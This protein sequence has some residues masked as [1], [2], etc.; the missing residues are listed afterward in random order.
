[1]QHSAIPLFDVR[2]LSAYENQIKGMISHLNKTLRLLDP[3][4]EEKML[5]LLSVKDPLIERA[6]NAVKDPY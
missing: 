2:Q 6:I 4:L 5:E 3:S 1:M